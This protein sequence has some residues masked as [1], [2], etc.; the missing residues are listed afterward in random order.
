MVVICGGVP[1]TWGHLWGGYPQIGEIL[2]E[3]T[4]KLGINLRGGTRKFQ[5]PKYVV[6]YQSCDPSQVYRFAASLGVAAA[7]IALC[8]MPG[9]PAPWPE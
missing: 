6:I 8:A 7:A 5:P 2:R 4:R 9:K 3:G 1:A